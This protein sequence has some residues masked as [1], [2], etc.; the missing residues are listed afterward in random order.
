MKRALFLSAI[1]CLGLAAS[2][3]AN[4]PVQVWYGLGNGY[5]SEFG[6]MS[7]YHSGHIPT[8]PY[9]AIHPPVYYSAPVPRTYGYSPFAYPAYVMTPEM[10]A[11]AVPKM[12]KNPHVEEVPKAAPK[13]KV[14]PKKKT[15]AIVTPQLNP[16]VEQAT[17]QV[18]SSRN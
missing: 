17:V 9:F 15:A 16:F 12:F 8:P 14:V 1:V 18:A 6:R 7:L 10:E 3:Q 13:T 4:P 2:V 11:P 5:G